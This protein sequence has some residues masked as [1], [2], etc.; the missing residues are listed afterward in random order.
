MRWGWTR[1]AGLVSALG[2]LGCPSDA[3]FQC[4]DDT[5]CGGEGQCE[6]NGYC[7][8]PDDGCASGRRFGEL[9]IP[10]I[11]DLCVPAEDPVPTS[12]EGSSA[13]GSGSTTTS[14][15]TGSLPDTPDPDDGGSSVSTS[16]PV[17]PTEATSSTTDASTTGQPIGRVEDG[18]TVLY[19]LQAGSTGL[20]PDSSSSSPPVDLE[21]QG[22]GYAFTPT[23][24]AFEG[25]AS[26][27]AR[28]SGSLSKLNF[29]C[30]ASNALT[31]ESWITP[32][33]TDVPG[34]ARILTYSRDSGARN[35]S[36]LL[37]QDI[38]GSKQGWKARLRTSV[39]SQNGTPDLDYLEAP[40]PGEARHFVF[41][42]EDDGD[43]HLYLDGVEVATGTR[44]SSFSTW[45]TD[46]TMSLAIGNELSLD[47]ALEA[48][49]HLVAIY[50]RALTA[51][52]VLQ[53]TDAGFE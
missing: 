16:E 22:S 31:L 11:A 25:D 23:G 7:S 47:R 35:F 29:E 40:R 30:S 49:V 21:L 26:T 27:I 5:A 53:N 18:L 4:D 37:G 14:A 42:H 8:F 39:T 1:V 48:E 44:A 24:L 9:A 15:G 17:D 28:S 41:V 43:E 3:S 36:L 2:L 6:A 52:E 34:P 20:V 46:G 32:G 10:G 51:D 12:S 38:D 19:Q 45:A 33:P 50:C 13:G